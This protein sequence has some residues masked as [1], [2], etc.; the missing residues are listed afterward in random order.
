MLEIKLSFQLDWDGAS[1]CLKRAWGDSEPQDGE[2]SNSW[3]LVL[4]PS[5]AI[6]SRSTIQSLFR[7][8]TKTER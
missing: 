1:L 3:Q 8:K 5:S 4:P 2:P 6:L 7:E